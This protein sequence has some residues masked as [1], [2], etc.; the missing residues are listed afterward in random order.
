MNAKQIRDYYEDKKGV[1]CPLTD[2]LIKS[3]YQ[4][5]KNMKGY[6]SYASEYS[7]DHPEDV[8]EVDY[9]KASP[10]QW[11]HLIKSWCD[12]REPNQTFSKSIKCGELYFWMAE[13]S[14][15]FQEDE[16]KQLAER[17]LTIAREHTLKGK[18]PLRTVESNLIIR[19]YC[20]D[21][22]KV[23]VENYKLNTPKTYREYGILNGFGKEE[24]SDEVAEKYYN[25]LAGLLNQIS[26]MNPDEYDDYAT[27]SSSVISM[28][29]NEILD[30]H[31][32]NERVSREVADELLRLIY[33]EILELDATEGFLY[34]IVLE[35]LIK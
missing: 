7:A 4:Q 17:A 22:I 20:F 16:L 34:D 31:V 25:R 33:N 2:C 15:E 32:R 21:R 3:G 27:V 10:N 5:S 6:T 35:V 9:T 29:L 24:L 11:W 28:D 8:I 14:G 19:D 26:V 23:A 1:K 30:I 12:R 18:M 13:V